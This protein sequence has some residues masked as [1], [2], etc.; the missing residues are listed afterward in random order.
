MNIKSVTPQY[1][2]LDLRVRNE[3]RPVRTE[4]GDDRDSN[5]RRERDESPSKDRLSDE[6]VEKVLIHVRSL[7]GVKQNQLTVQCVER[8]SRQFFVIN[9]LDGKVVRRFTAAEGWSLLKENETGRPPHILNK[10]A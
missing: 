5:G 8:G 4:H 6:E 3:E 10:S 1:M 2:N 9:D 7:D